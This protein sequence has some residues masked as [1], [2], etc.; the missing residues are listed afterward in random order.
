M[1]LDELKAK[2]PNITVMDNE[3]W[4]IWN[5]NSTEKQKSRED[6]PMGS[7]R[8]W[9]KACFEETD[10]YLPVPLPDSVSNAMAKLKGWK[11]RRFMGIRVIERHGLKKQGL[12]GGYKEKGESY[13]FLGQSFPLAV[14]KALKYTF[15]RPYY[16]GIAYLWGHIKSIIYRKERINDAEI[17][18]YYLYTRPQELKAYYKEKLKKLIRK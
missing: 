7:A 16:P 8:V 6:L 10:G 13:F 15:T 11:T 5:S 2:N 18:K 12:W 4:H 14:L 3:F 17:L 1:I 9:R